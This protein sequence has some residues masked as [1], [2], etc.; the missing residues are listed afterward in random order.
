MFRPVVPVWLFFC[1]FMPSHL[2]A[3]TNSPP[4]AVHGYPG[5]WSSGSSPCLGSGLYAAFPGTASFVSSLVL[6]PA[7]AVVY[8][9]GNELNRFV[10][11]LAGI[12][13]SILVSSVNIGGIYFALPEASPCREGMLV[14]H[15]SNLALLVSTVVLGAV[16]VAKSRAGP[17]QAKQE[18]IIREQKKNQAY[19]SVGE[20]SKQTKN[21]N[22][23]KVVQTFSILLNLSFDS[24]ATDEYQ[25]A[26]KIA[27]KHP[28]CFLKGTGK[29]LLDRF[30][31]NYKGLPLRKHNAS[32]NKILSFYYT[33]EM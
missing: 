5:G 7:N 1:L 17:L 6:L 29:Q 28:Q 15:I 22:C 31:M 13:T 20:L 33:F 3:Q 21:V 30:N 23:N 18:S 10:W 12:L 24:E 9:K 26:E 19:T 14:L 25:Y 27:E 32:S 16:N 4:L 8:A 11:G 2:F